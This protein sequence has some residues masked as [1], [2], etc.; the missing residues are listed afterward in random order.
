MKS[1]HDKKT[2][3]PEKKHTQEF[4]YQI[5]IPVIVS[6]LIVIGVM[7]L[8]L[9]ASSQSPDINEKWAQIV[10]IL[11]ILPFIPIGLIS[12]IGII[13]IIWLIHHFQGLIPPQFSKFSKSV[14][15]LGNSLQGLTTKTT[16]P[17]IYAKSTLAGIARLF[18]LAARRK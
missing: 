7:I 11:M 17:I 15:F 13:A 8:V 2:R 12:L 14:N 6:G 9:S 16:F 4:F 5:L 10:L 3:I 18:N 1:T